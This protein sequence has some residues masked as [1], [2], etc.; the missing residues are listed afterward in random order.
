VSATAVAYFRDAILQTL[1][2]TCASLIIALALGI[3]LAYLMARGG[4]MGRVVSGAVTVVRAIPDLVLAIVF[5]VALGLG[6]GPAIVALGIHYAAVIG[7]MFSDVIASVRREP[8][9]V[10][11][12]TGATAGAAVLIGLVPTAWPGII[13][14]GVYAFESIT[15]AA[16]IVG[17]VGAGGIGAVLVQQ[18]NMADYHG[19]AI[20]VVLLAALIALIEALGTYFRLHATPRAIALALGAVAA[21]GIAALALA[22]DP[23][24]RML[25]TA[26]GHLANYVVNA[27]PQVN[28]EIVQT[29]LGGALQ[30]ILVALA[31][32]ILGAIL[33]VPFALLIAWPV[34]RGWMRGTGWRPLSLPFEIVSRIVLTAVRAVPPI[35]IGL[36]GVVLIGIG[37]VAGAFAL[38][39]H[40]A[41]VL[42][43]LLAESFDVA[44]RAPAEALVANGATGTSATLVALVPAAFGA[45]LAHV[46]YR[47]EWNVR[48]S[49]AL[50]MV[51]AGGLGQA[52]FNAQ[53]LLFYR[54]LSSYVLVAI[55]LVL[56][57]DAIGARL[58][59][60]LR[61]ERLAVE[62]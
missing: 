15:R 4:R 9:E 47:F 48:A 14:F 19:F 13:G 42:G 28:A 21:L 25:A 41:G 37:P 11:V 31:G 16:V 8:A 6:P 26:P 39:L 34:A 7:K 53:Q 46:L 62:V 59:A 43:K 44:D 60:G 50:G 54:Q 33:A 51:G 10:L 36:I 45:M 2:I 58:R 23:P 35:A 27:V 5:V 56:I 17:V 18:L 57:V 32:T 55:V 30:C 3:P 1:G 29:A 40:T 61:L 20:S 52:I 49:T 38:T 22:P 12:A 24:W